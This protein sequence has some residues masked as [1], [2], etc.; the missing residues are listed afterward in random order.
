MRL[1]IGV[2][3]LAT[4]IAAPALAAEM[5]VKVPPA[6]APVPY[7]WTGFYVGGDVGGHWSSDNDPA[8]LSVNN[9]YSGPIPALLDEAAPVTLNDTGLAGGFHVGYNWQMNSLVY[10]VEGDFTWLHGTANR[11]TTVPDPS[12]LGTFFQ[13]VDSAS[14]RWISTVR[15][16]FGWAADRFLIYVSGGV[17]FS[18]W[19]LNHSFA[20]IPASPANNAGASSNTVLRTGGT[21]GGGVEYAVNNNWT[22]R[23]DYL[24][25]N[26]GKV[27][28]NVFEPPQNFPEDFVI[29]THPEHLSENLLRF[30][31]SYKF[32]SP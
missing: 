5:A 29:F 8:Y 28:N 1:A 9:Q 12:L 20:E 11:N 23:A 18:D 22:I 4:L 26:F 17:A 27:T 7:S 10:G 30:G 15:A 13:F 3:A 14:D 24:Y 21:V 19:A 2:T 25:A 31:I 16:R 32:G 6:A